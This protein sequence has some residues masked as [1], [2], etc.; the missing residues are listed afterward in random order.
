MVH[1]TILKGVSHRNYVELR[2]LVLRTNYAELILPYAVPTR[3]N[4][5]RDVKGHA[6]WTQK[7]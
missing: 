4:T 6:R 7:N 2:R 5:P 3:D 1:S